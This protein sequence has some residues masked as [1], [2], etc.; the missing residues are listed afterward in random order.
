[1]SAARRLLLLSALLTSAWLTGC[2]T[3]V[4]EGTSSS[5]GG[6]GAGSVG[7]ANGGTTGGS[8]GQGS[9]SSG[10]TVAGSSSGSSGGASGS[11]GSSEPTRGIVIFLRTEVIQA[12]QVVLAGFSSRTGA[13]ELDP[14]D[15]TGGLREGSCC[16]R[17]P[18]ATDGGLA[19]D[20]GAPPT[21]GGPVTAGALAIS[22]KGVV[23]GQ[24]TPGGNGGYAPLTG[25]S[26]APGD[27]LRVR[28]A[29]AEV[30]AFDE[31]VVAPT[32]LA[33]TSPLFTN[34]LAPPQVK[35]SEALRVTWNGAGGNRNYV[36]LRTLSADGPS[37]VCTTTTGNAVTL[38]GTLLSRMPT[39]GYGVLLVVKSSEKQVTRPTSEITVSA[40]TAAGGGV[41][42]AP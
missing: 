9:G 3:P 28:A 5:S 20:G 22:I 19:D 34:P 33:V 26:W 11:T 10:G 35:A 24:M 18:G 7:G 12:T 30:P 17:G 21:D 42:F 16:Y 29:G 37:V 2:G 38:P 31:Q 14:D 40:A 25:K 8:S 6:I 39:S 1:M 41:Q 4:A 32:S 27:T 15:C 13:L 36:T 23:S